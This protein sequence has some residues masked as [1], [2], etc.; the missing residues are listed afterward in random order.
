VLDYTVLQ[1]RRD[2]GIRLALGAQRADIVRR[3][4]VSTD[5]MGVRSAATA[6]LGA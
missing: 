6:L 2:I 5:A 1:Q 3:V 4:H